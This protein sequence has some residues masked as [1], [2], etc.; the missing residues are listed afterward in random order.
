MTYPK[1][2]STDTQDAIEQLYCDQILQR[3]PLYAA[4]WEKFI[5]VQDNNISGFLRPYGLKIPPALKHEK[6]AINNTYFEITY[7]HY[8]LFCH[9]A[10][11][12]YQIGEL[13]KSL[14]DTC[15]KQRHFKH[16][17][18][19]ENIYFHL[20]IVMNQLYQLWGLLFV[21]KGICKRKKDGEP[22]G[23]RK[24][25]KAFLVVEKKK[26]LACLLEKV[27]NEITIIRNNITHYVRGFSRYLSSTKE[28]V[29]PNSIRK[30]EMWEKSLRK[31]AF[32]VTTAKTNSDL[33]RMQCMVNQFHEILIP[34]LEKYL[35]SKKLEI[36]KT[37]NR[38][39]YV[40]KK[41]SAL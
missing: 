3:F 36:N 24:A 33:V 31:T 21:L 40:S 38:G 35:C 15:A 14:Q 12:H 19:F 34:E 11:A 10:G 27:E 28:Y 8:T 7:V 18:A 22:D 29:I 32:R 41:M 13:K 26:S 20:G 37:K 23:V 30:R 9:L 6:K 25:L 39:V 17:E 5:G 4:F 2:F 1:I 16:W